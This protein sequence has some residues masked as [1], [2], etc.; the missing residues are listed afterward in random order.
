MAVAAMHMALPDAPQPED[1]DHIKHPR[2][3]HQDER[4]GR[5]PRQERALGDSAPPG[6]GL[7]HQEHDRT[8]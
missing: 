4:L 7:R 5:D 8:R 3:E 6:A 1:V 2:H